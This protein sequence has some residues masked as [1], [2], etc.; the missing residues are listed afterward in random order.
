MATVTPASAQTPSTA[1]AS[2]YAGAAFTPAV[3]D[4]IAVVFSATGTVDTGADATDNQGGTYTLLATAT[5]TAAHS[6]YI[7]VRDTL[8]TS[9]VSHTVTCTLAVDPA[10]GAEVHSFTIAGMSAAGATAMRQSAIQSN[11]TGGTP[12]PVFSVAALTGNPLIGAASVA[13][14]PPNL[15]PP[16]GWTEAYDHGHASPTGGT[17]SVYRSSGFT[18]TTVTWGSS[19]GTVDFGALVVEFD[20]S[21]ITNASPVTT[22]VAAVAAIATPAIT[23]LTAPSIST[24]AAVAA[25]DTPVVTASGDDAQVFIPAEVAATTAIPTPTVT[26]GALVS[27]PATVAAVAAIATPTV[28]ATLLI[29]IP[30]AVAAVAAVDTP[31]TTAGALTTPTTVAAVAAVDTPGSPIPDQDATVRS[32]FW[33]CDQVDVL[34]DSTSHLCDGLDAL[35]LSVAAT[36]TI[37][38]PTV[39][40]A[41]APLTLT[42]VAATAAVPTP[43]IVFPSFRHSSVM[44]KH[45]D[46]WVQQGNVPRRKEAPRK[47][48]A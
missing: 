10:T 20:A 48:R 28:A 15:T 47:I 33:L 6:I 31:A 7:L 23:L 41:F 3:G 26:A 46:R 18:S 5:R 45:R 13:S 32:A 11:N 30:A 37:P 9:A 2:S 22:T 34:C 44:R 4:L 38:T 17:E 12:A 42:T 14:S 29:A 21:G 25:I 40:A 27:V 16:S 35:Y 43:T 36:T 24:V 19:T 8:V 39:T 1:N